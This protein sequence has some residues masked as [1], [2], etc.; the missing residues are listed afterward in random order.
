MWE[1]FFPQDQVY[2]LELWIWSNC[3]AQKVQME[4]EKPNYGKQVASERAKSLITE[5]RLIVDVRNHRNF[6]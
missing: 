2:L 5:E 4:Q 3:Q 1:A 6:V